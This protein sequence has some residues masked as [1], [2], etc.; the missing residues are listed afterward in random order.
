MTKIIT[1]CSIVC[2]FTYNSTTLSQKSFMHDNPFHQQG[3]EAIERGDTKE[4]EKY[5]KLSVEEYAYAPSY[6]EL[7]KIYKN[8][9]TIR[10]R[11]KAR[12]FIRKAIWKEPDKIE[13]RLL[14][15]E[16][17]EYFS[18]KMA[19]D[20]Y[21]DILQIDSICITA[22]FHLGRI[23]ELEFYEYNKSVRKSGS[24]P[25]L[26]LEA[27]ALED[28]RIAEEFFNRIINYD[29]SRIDS[30]LHLGCLYE[31]I[32]EPEK[33]IPLLQKV[34]AL[35]PANKQAYLYLG[36]FYY[37]T[38]EIESSYLAYQKALELMSSE[39]KN[40][41]KI[42]SAEML[43]GAKL[44]SEL[45][46]LT[47][48]ELSETINDFWSSSDPLYLTKYNERLLEHYSRVAYSNL[49]FSI[50]KLGVTGW[51]SDRGE[52]LVRYGEPLE[53]VRYR[54][55]INAGG[56]TQLMLKTDLWIYRD[57]VLGFVDESWSGNF[58][59][60]TPSPGSRHH[61]QFVGDTDFFVSDLRRIDPES[62]EPKFEGP[63]FDVPFN[64]AQFK[65]IEEK[66]NNSTQLYLNYALNSYNQ[67]NSKDRYPFAHKYG[68]FFR[69]NQTDLQQKRIKSINELTP[70]RKLKL[71]LNNEVHINSIMFEAKPDTG[72]LAFEII[73]KQDNA[74]STNHFDFKIKKFKEDELDISDIILAARVDNSST[75]YTSIK[76]RDLSILP[77]P[78]Q[79]FYNTND[80]YIYYEIYNLTLDDNNSAN[81]EQ[82]I[83]ISKP[84]EETGIG[85]VLNSVLG[86]F[87][88]GDE[89]D[90]VTL[91]TNYQS[92]DRNTQVFLQLDMGNYEKG[93]YII[94]IIIEDKLSDNI[95]SE[96][97]LL[98]WR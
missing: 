3:L 98:R 7:A 94:R 89:D 6:F 44:R 67:F 24:D 22:L 34:I 48:Y 35:K 72:Q 92:F 95:V 19:Y 51:N 85:N 80:I 14:L 36:L 11:T 60:S 38:S 33:G 78:L 76:R 97:T 18:N 32:G 49:R 71:G 13:Y 39:E 79:T 26:S 54:P 83:T 15:A 87:G 61:S 90:K 63:V 27:Y 28:F 64:I 82:R 69:S 58:R 65:N 50:P 88:L 86:F 41:F 31:D 93:N 45:A 53:R 74:I 59:F 52:I 2:L 10:S 16:L 8:I 77:N 81:F 66:N 1:Y 47:D 42:N 12:K 55:Y 25:S 62:Y 46:E 5:F 20:V 91:A 73:M 40:D 30:Y 84:S 57:K 9:N 21:E 43:F 29:S 17:M 4:A 68:L 75:K 70:N 37:K 23:K 56:R 96:E